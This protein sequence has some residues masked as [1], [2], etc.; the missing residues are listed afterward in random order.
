MLDNL[1]LNKVDKELKEN[2]ESSIFLMKHLFLNMKRLEDKSKSQSLNMSLTIKLYNM[3]SNI[4]QMSFKK[5]LLNICLQKESQKKLNTKQFKH[6]IFYPMD[7]NNNNMP[8]HSTLNNILNPPSNN[9]SLFN[10]NNPLLLKA[11]HIIKAQFK[12]L[13]DNQL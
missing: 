9:N 12:L 13:Q 6:R 8:K 2:L 1:S 7:N 11:Q 3:M 4:F 10:T 5:K